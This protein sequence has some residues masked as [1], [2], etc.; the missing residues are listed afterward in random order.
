MQRYL[1]IGTPVA[2]G[3]A[4]AERGDVL[5]IRGELTAAEAAYADA[6]RYGFEPQPGLALLWLAQGR[7]SAAVAA[8]QRLAAEPRPGG[9]AP[10]AAARAVEILLAAGL[11]DEA[12][13]VAE[14]LDRCAQLLDTP[15]VRGLAGYAAATVRAGARARP[16]AACR[17]CAGRGRR[18][19]PI[20]AA[21][22]V[23]RCRALTRAG[24]PTA[25][26]H[27]LGRPRADRGRPASSP[28]SG[29]GRRTRR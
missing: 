28:G 16:K 29:R 6:G 1:Q 27:R 23:A 22:E 15:T 19:R 2:A 21:Y 11:V 12:A 10:P 24:L 3:L 26:R 7:T 17:G 5:R 18:L 14:R 4:L 8:V 20:G 13:D 9:S 25:R